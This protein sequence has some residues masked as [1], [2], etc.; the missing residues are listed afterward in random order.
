MCGITGFVGQGDLDILARMTNQL[1]HRGPDGIGLHVEAELPVFLGHRRLAVVDLSSGTQPMW[2]ETRDVCVI[3]NGEIYNHV[4]LR[5]ELETLGHRF[6]SLGSDTEVLVHG[7]EEWGYDLPRRLNG[8][9]AFAIWD[10]ERA[11]LFLARDRFGEKPLYYS[12]D[13]GL[14]AF[15]SELSSLA[16]HPGV[17]TSF[18]P[19][20]L[21]KFFAY[22]YIPSPHALY[23]GCWK[24]PGGHSLTVS[25]P[26]LKVHQRAYWTFSLAPDPALENAS[27]CDLID[28]LEGL[29]INAARRRLMSDVPVGVF[30]SGGIDSSVILA[31][32]SK[33]HA[34]PPL[35]SFTIGF[36]E[37]SFDE[38][39]HART[40][41]TLLKTAHHERELDFTSA[42]ALIPRILSK[43]DEP[44]GDA[45]ILPTSLLCGFAREKVTVAL[46]GDGGDELFAGYDPFIA[47]K[48]G[49]IYEKIVPRWGHSRLRDLVGILPK[50]NANMSF[51][52][53]LRRM[54]MGLSYPSEIR[55][56]IWMS[57]LEPS[58]IQ[59]VL[60]MPVHAEEVYD[61]AITLWE[62]GGKKSSVDKAQE[63][64]TRFYLQDNILTKSDRA[65]MMHS[66]ETRAVLLDNDIVD[67][68]EKLPT[69]F[70][71]RGNERKYLLKQVARRMLPNEIV[72]RKKKG[73][74][75]PL[76][77]WMK[78]TGNLAD[79]QIPGINQK[80][81]KQ[82]QKEHQS[83]A[84]DYR[85]FLWCI[86]SLK[87]LSQ[88]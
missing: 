8:M 37:K 84:G 9:F 57:P 33:G 68:C 23:Q 74:G 78:D 14:F 51:D 31:G 39:V 75:I 64:F 12:A 85:Y 47:L 82:A 16:T 43:M 22:G 55:L 60:D 61:D 70:K 15:S 49:E 24:L 46:S 18:N 17:G 38:S 67:F 66:L 34:G 86:L 29:L 28:E 80:F 76:Q 19:K 81:V 50:S 10:R 54:L 62:T 41:A 20:A 5:R 59:D 30:L 88:P 36:S 3:F 1:A 45:S 56:P 25:L 11:Q 72:D 65:S 87:Y 79:A 52:F 21:A 69:H 4:D 27:E 7:W 58:D 2:N 63:F 44:L 40:V 35:H 73:F 83:G 71:L 13:K 48:L 53:K 77:K 26:D 42:R 32:L 6:T